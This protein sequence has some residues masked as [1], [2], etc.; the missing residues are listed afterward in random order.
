MEQKI[1]FV[2]RKMDDVTVK[3]KRVILVTNVIPA[4]MTITRRVIM[5]VSLAIVIPEDAL[6]FHAPLLK[7][8][9]LVTLPTM[10]PDVNLNAGV[11]LMEQKN[12]VCN[13]NSGQC[14]NCKKGYTGVECD[15]CANTAY[16]ED[17]LCKRKYLYNS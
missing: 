3:V 12:Q 2:I 5:S 16:K 17:N 9:V 6:V 8:N 7:A 10:E 1:N 11:T 4:P 15:S 13:T 14:K